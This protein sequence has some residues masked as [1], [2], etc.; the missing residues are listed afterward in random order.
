MLVSLGP[1]EDGIAETIVTVGVD[2]RIAV[3]YAYEWHDPHA[4]LAYGYPVGSTIAKGRITSMDLSRAHAA[5][6][7]VTLVT[8][9]EAGQLGKGSR[10]TATLLGGPDIEHAEHGPAQRAPE[11]R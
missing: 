7:V 10:N 4:G 2:R 8:T 3:R 9:N 11:L 6:G 5:P 1:S